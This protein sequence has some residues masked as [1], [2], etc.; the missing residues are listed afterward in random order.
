MEA[1]EH[2]YDICVLAGFGSDR[3]MEVMNKQTVHTSQHHRESP[4]QNAT[5]THL[6]ILHPVLTQQLWDMATEFG[7]CYDDVT[8]FPP[9][10]KQL[11]AEKDSLPMP[12]NMH[13]MIQITKVRHRKMVA[14]RKERRKAREKGG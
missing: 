7:Y 5:W 3:C 12:D 8:I 9:T 6:Y 2:Y 1:V 14:A 11:K 10:T 13:D 4:Y